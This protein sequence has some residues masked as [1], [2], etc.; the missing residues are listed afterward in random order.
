M[1]TS[2]TPPPDAAA[3]GYDMVNEAGTC[4]AAVGPSGPAI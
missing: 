1:V 2:D 4:A 3:N